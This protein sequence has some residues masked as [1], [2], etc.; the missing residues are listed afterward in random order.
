M[1]TRK[2]WNREIRDLE[3]AIDNWD[4]KMNL[5]D[6]EMAFLDD[7]NSG[8]IKMYMQGNYREYLKQ[9]VDIFSNKKDEEA[10]VLGKYIIR[11]KNACHKP[12]NDTGAV[13]INSTLDMNADMV[14]SISIYI[15]GLDKRP[16]EISIYDNFLLVSPDRDPEAIKQFLSDLDKVIYGIPDVE[17][18]DSSEDSDLSSIN[19]ETERLLDVYAER[20]RIAQALGKMAME[21]KY[22]VGIKNDSED[23]EYVILYIDLPTGQVSWHIPRRELIGKFP[24]YNGN[25][26]GHQIE[27]KIERVEEYIKKD[28][29]KKK[30]WLITLDDEG[31]TS[32]YFEDVK[33]DKYNNAI[34]RNQITIATD[35]VKNVTK[36]EMIVKNWISMEE[37]EI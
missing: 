9:M 2:E 18:P 12:T 20:N 25:W 21:M 26:D 37:V 34:C 35:G 28:V 16:T 1:V 19:A 23:K 6:D 33:I 30:L 7:I 31:E 14:L 5:T 36:Y 4:F 13:W 10:I 8:R 22:N 29:E 3:D 24:E 17:D 11:F 27:T 32:I 15:Y